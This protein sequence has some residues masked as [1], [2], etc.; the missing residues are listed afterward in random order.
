MI[1]KFVMLFLSGFY[2]FKPPCFSSEN[3]YQIFD[4]GTLNTSFSEAICINDKGHV[5]G[6]YEEAGK[7]VYFIWS[8]TEGLKPLNFPDSVKDVWLKKINDQGAIIGM[9]KYKPCGIKTF[10]MDRD[11]NFTFF[12]T[13]MDTEIK[14]LETYYSHTYYPVDINNNGQVVGY[15]AINSTS[16]MRKIPFLWDGEKILRLSVKAFSENPHRTNVQAEALSINDHGIIVGKVQYNT[17]RFPN[18]GL[19]AI[20][21]DTNFGYS[22]YIDLHPHP[23]L[24]RHSQS[25]AFCINNNNKIG[26]DISGVGAFWIKS[27][28]SNSIGESWNS[29]KEY[30]IEVRRSEKIIFKINDRDDV[31]FDKIICNY[32]EAFIE[33]NR[34]SSVL[35]LFEINNSKDKNFCFDKV[36]KFI[37]INN[38]R[39]II[40]EV[41]MEDGRHHGVL[42]KV[43][44]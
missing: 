32:D 35:S 23:Q 25:R 12:E 6:R 4:F 7:C 41:T 21:W 34:S 28:G 18:F 16:Q 11:G 19:H 9:F 24:H 8:E 29:S 17:T 39:E 43:I 22:H 10:I 40:A 38:N 3:R 31:L 5:L 27:E 2:I 13:E 33:K 15:I 14:Y 1:L 26:G 36:E 42:I 20:A 44:K 30:K 37:D